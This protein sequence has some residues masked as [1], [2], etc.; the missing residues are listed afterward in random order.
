VE[1]LIA[2]TLLKDRYKELSFFSET[3]RKSSQKLVLCLVEMVKL[4]SAIKELEALQEV[5][6]CEGCM[7][8][9]NGVCTDLD[10]CK[11]DNRLTDNFKPKA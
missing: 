6:S 1:K 9:S 7:D 5:K 10:W 11:R 3:H 8:F 2:L 4:N